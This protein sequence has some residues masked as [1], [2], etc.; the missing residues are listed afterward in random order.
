MLRRPIVDP[1]RNH[2]REPKWIPELGPPYGKH[3]IREQIGG[4]FWVPQF[5]VRGPSHTARRGRPA[6]SLFV[7]VSQPQAG[8]R[9]VSGSFHCCFMGGRV[10]QGGSTTW[11]RWS[12]AQFG[13]SFGRFSHCGSPTILSW[14]LLAFPG[15]SWFLQASTGLSWPR[16]ASHG[17][18][19]P[20]V[21]FPSP[22]WPL[23][24]LPGLSWPLLAYPGL[25]WRL[26]VA[27]G[28]SWLL[29][30]FFLASPGISWLLLASPGFSWPLLASSGCSWP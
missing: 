8:V 5:G 19:Q 14:P 25:S 22:S 2:K 4:P 9:A 15:L 30:T 18:S 24:A 20:L 28:L 13:K 11:A 16:L 10:V 3:Y 6:S 1:R 7:S 29:L 27:P 17:F 21:A 23:P 26:L 12:A